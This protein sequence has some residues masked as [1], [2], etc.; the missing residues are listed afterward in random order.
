M[1][2]IPTDETTVNP[3]NSYGISKLSQESLALHLGR[4]YE[5]P[6][7]AMR[8]S[9]TQ[10]AGQSF[11]NAYSGI[12]RIFAV[13]ALL[14]KPFPIYED[15]RQWRD[16]VYVGDVVAA[17]VM[18]VEDPRMDYQAFNVGG[19]E[20]MTVTEYA[21]LVNRIAQTA[22]PLQLGKRYRVGDTR[23]I[24]SDSSKLLA[25]GWKQLKSVPEIIDEY[26]D[27]LGSQPLPE[28]VTDTA[29]ERMRVLGAVGVA[30]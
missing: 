20:A 11:H 13:C 30:G 19:S 25:R 15:G 14:G 29:Q 17:N 10:G 3:Q 12:C 7:V 28:D 9:I 24:V 6:S 4:R 16:Y 26:L 23:H 22:L 8:Y 27:W 1:S 2:S 21:T 5:I 18:A